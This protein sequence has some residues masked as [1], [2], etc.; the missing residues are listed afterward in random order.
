MPHEPA[1]A[2]R[3]STPDPTWHASAGAESPAVAAAEARATS[4][5]RVADVEAVARARLVT[6]PPGS[7]LV[8]VAALLSNAQIG[9]VVVCN[10]AGEPLGTVTETV[11]V[12]RLGL[13]AADFFTTTAGDV[14]TR[15]D[16]ACTPADLLSDVLATMHDRGLLHVLLVDAERRV[17]GVVNA[18]DGLRA[19]LASGNAEQ[20]LMRDYVTGV[21][22]R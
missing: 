8:E 13:G 21:G 6:V 2:T 17:Q 22:Y 15:S 11:L 1:S 7:L 12:R 10:D 20:D 9:V 19:L 3:P 4:P 5:L 16:A 14:M 18:R